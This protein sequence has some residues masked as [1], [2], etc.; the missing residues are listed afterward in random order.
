MENKKFN[1]DYSCKHYFGCSTIMAKN[2]EDALVGLK[3][4][5]ENNHQNTSPTTRKDCGVKCNLKI[6]IK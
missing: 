5:I 1:C 4:N 6:K 3:L 2:K